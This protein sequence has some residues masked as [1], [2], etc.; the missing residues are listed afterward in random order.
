M[1]QNYIHKFFLEFLHKSLII[2]FTNLFN[3]L[4][5]SGLFHCSMNSVQQ[6]NIFMT[7]S[8]EKIDMA[9]TYSTKID[10]TKHQ[11]KDYKGKLYLISS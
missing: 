8:T 1:Y 11:T 3:N 5:I 2:R 10:K 7:F 6:F 4:T 9:F